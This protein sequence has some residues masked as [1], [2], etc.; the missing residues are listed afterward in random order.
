MVCGFDVGPLS[1]SVGL[2]VGAPQEG[3]GEDLFQ[4]EAVVGEPRPVADGPLQAF[5]GYLHLMICHT[6]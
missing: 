2:Q 4:R 1:D 6:G 5:L 3:H